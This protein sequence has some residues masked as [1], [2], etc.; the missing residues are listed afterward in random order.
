MKI[1]LEE[2]DYI[3]AITPFRN[4]CSFRPTFKQNGDVYLGYGCECFVN[5]V[6]G[7]EEQFVRMIRRSNDKLIKLDISPEIRVAMLKVEPCKLCGGARFEAPLE[8]EP[9]EV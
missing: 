5:L 4:G 2:S 7:A 1:I 6:T 9:N 3:E 8:E